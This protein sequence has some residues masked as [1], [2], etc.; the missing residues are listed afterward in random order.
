MSKNLIYHIML[1][2]I[3]AFWGLA[4]PIMKTG[5]TTINAGTFLGLR[6]MLAALVLMLIF[7]KRIIA[8]F[9]KEMLK[10]V[11]L[12]SASLF[13]DYYCYSMGLKTTTSINCSFYAGIAAI[14]VPFLMFIFYKK[15]LKDQN[16]LPIIS[17]F[18]GIYLLSSDSGQI[19]FLIGDI[20][21]LCSSFFFAIYIILS[22]KNVKQYD[23]ITVSVLQMT[24]VGVMSILSS[25][26]I[27]GV[28]SISQFTSDT[29]ISLVF[30]GIFTTA[31]PFTIQHWVQPK[32]SALSAAITYSAM[33][34]FGTIF[35]II[36]LHETIGMRG[37]S[38]GILIV[39]SIAL[40]EIFNNKKKKSALQETSKI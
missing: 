8:N 15:S 23:P 3:T 24:M 40:T 16:W 38:G 19:T 29:L 17:I 2:V 7:G 22:S 27:E 11:F 6:F 35:S 12:V 18:L 13:I 37:I 26:V 21:C 20:F 9:R 30:L 34:L 4:F 5:V 33:P 25:F 32:V 1:I 10:P 31:L 14:F 39:I 36:L 28:P